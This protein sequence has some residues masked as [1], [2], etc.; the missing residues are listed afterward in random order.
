[1]FDVRLLESAILGAHDLS[2]IFFGND[3]MLTTAFNHFFVPETQQSKSDNSLISK[4]EGQEKEDIAWF[5][6]QIK[7]YHAQ[8]TLPDPDFPLQPDCYS[9]SLTLSEKYCEMD[10]VQRKLPDE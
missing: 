2:G 10:A 4:P 6:G 1:M 8:E 7:I 3:R 9:D 5:Y